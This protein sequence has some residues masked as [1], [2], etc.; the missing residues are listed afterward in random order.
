MQIRVCNIDWDC[1]E[2]DYSGLGLPEEDVIEIPVEEDDSM[3]DE[4]LQDII[5]DTL[6]EMYGF[7]QNG[8]VYDIIEE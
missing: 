5:S 4:E 6:S 2:E 7:C 1:D 3:T 8:F